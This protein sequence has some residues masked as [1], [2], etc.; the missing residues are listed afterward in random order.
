MS[1]TNPKPYEAGPAMARMTE[2]QVDAARPAERWADVTTGSPPYR[3]LWCRLAEDAPNDPPDERYFGQEVRPSGVDDDGHL[4][5]EPVPGGLDQVVIHNMS[6]RAAGT[7]LLES[8]TVVRVE[9]RLDRRHP[10]EL[11]Y[12][13]GT[14]V[15]TERLARIVSFEGPG[16]TVQPVR[17]AAE[18]F[19]DDGAPIGGVANLGELWPDEAGYLAGPSGFDRYVQIFKT[20]AGWAM[21]LHPPRMV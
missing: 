21:L 7:H 20:S 11:V 15:L 4:T 1:G 9:E 17:C 8:D 3:L 19:A 18:G 5:W 12:V 14:A 2:R 6:E 16:Y 10:P 13:T